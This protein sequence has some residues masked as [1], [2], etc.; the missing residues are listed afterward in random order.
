MIDTIEV[1]D[2]SVVAWGSIIESSWTQLCVWWEL[3]VRPLSLQV[4]L[5]TAHPFLTIGGIL[6]HLPSS[7]HDRSVSGSFHHPLAHPWDRSLSSCV[8]SLMGLWVVTMAFLTLGNGPHSSPWDP[9]QG[10]LPTSLLQYC[11]LTNYP[12]IQCQIAMS[13]FCLRK[14]RLRNTTFL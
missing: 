1:C 7:P 12:R 5:I 13:I 11:C 8:P 14:L 9:F 10:R 3:L 6:S 4:F 2:V